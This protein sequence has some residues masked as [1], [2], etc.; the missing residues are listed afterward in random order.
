M[1]AEPAPSCTSS[2]AP[3]G[4]QVP[5]GPE[6]GLG[7]PIYDLQ[8][9]ASCERPSKCHSTCQFPKGCRLLEIQ[10][11]SPKCRLGMGWGIQ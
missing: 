11:S 3:S 9:E 2:P 8:T 6:A 4:H 10:Q 1:G 5:Q 7:S